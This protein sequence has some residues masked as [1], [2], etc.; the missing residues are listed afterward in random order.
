M[1][2]SPYIAEA[3]KLLREAKSVAVLTGAGVSAESG[4]PTFRASDGLWEGHRIEDV[5]SPD[6]WER[7]SN[8]VWTFY[9]LRRTN[10]SEVQPNPGHY[11]LAEMEKIWGEDFNLI[12]QNVD[13]LHQRAGNTRVWELHG[14]L[15]RTE[16][17]GCGDIVDQGLTDLGTDPRCKKCGDLVRPNIVW[18]GESLPHEVWKKAQEATFLCD[19]FLVIG[20]SAVVYPAAGLVRLAKQR[21]DIVGELQPAKVIE[22]NIT[23]SDVVT[24]V[25]VG[26]YG[27]SGEV[28]PKILEGIR[29]G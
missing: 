13:G 10:V 3:I 7:D 15:N 20:T 26:I 23:P 11:A 29:K 5:A 19:V 25:D 14:A 27:P 28:L 18:F 1:D 24:Y 16:C 12:T 2:L 21:G 9:N 4:V 8:L 22:I 17:T 6:G